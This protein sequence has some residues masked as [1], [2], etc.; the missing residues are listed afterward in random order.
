M[1]FR[2]CWHWALAG[3]V[4]GGCLGAVRVFLPPEPAGR[5]IKQ[6]Q[7][8]QLISMKD[9]EGRPALKDARISRH[10]ADF[11]LL[12][13]TVSGAPP[14]GQRY[15]VEFEGDPLTVWYLAPRPYSGSKLLAEY[16]H[17]A[18]DVPARIAWWREDRVIVPGY[19]L[20]GGALVGSFMP[21]LLALLG[22]GVEE[23]RSIVLRWH[24]RRTHR[25]SVSLA[26]RWRAWRAA[27]RMPAPVR[28]EKPGEEAAG[29]PEPDAS[30]LADRFNRAGPT[31]EAERAALDVEE[32]RK[33]ALKEEDFYPTEE[34]RRDHDRR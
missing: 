9:R 11:D 22:H 20:I 6:G 18:A 29:A 17:T 32:A 26:E 10:D 3:L 27:W 30:A 12:T 5:H 7:F 31:S 24:H 21:L 25:R 14:H 28:D 13:A 34:R 16:L 15:P 2:T 1:W 8:E 23:D 19:A 4:L 33:F